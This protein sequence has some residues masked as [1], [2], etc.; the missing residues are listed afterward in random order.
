MAGYMSLHE[1][2][3]QPTI[4]FSHCHH[5]SPRSSNLNM[6]NRCQLSELQKKLNWDNSESLWIQGELKLG[7]L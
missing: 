7:M 5:Q 4:L 6:H 2:T 3:P 1:G